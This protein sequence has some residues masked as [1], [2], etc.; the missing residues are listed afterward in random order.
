MVNKEDNEQ[1]VPKWW[2]FGLKRKLALKARAERL[3]AEEEEFKKVLEE[4]KEILRKNQ[5]VVDAKLK[6]AGW[7]LGGIGYLSTDKMQVVRI[8]SLNGKVYRV[9][10]SLNGGSNIE[11]V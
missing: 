8:V 7:T 11:K 2:Q 9:V 1:V 3:A 5:E 10:T 4:K 6:E